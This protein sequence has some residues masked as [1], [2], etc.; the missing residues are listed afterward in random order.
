MSVKNRKDKN[1]HIV[2]HDVWLE[3]IMNEYGENLMKL[4]NSYRFY[5]QK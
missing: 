1:L 5:L 4:A 2:D 3:L